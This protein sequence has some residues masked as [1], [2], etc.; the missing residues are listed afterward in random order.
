MDDPDKRDDADLL[1][2]LMLAERLLAPLATADISS[3]P[4]PSSSGADELMKFL[5]RWIG[6]AGRRTFHSSDTRLLAEHYEREIERLGKAYEE[7]TLRAVTKER[8]RIVELEHLVGQLRQGQRQE[9]EALRQRIARLQREAEDLAKAREDD[10]ARQERGHAA[11]LSRRRAETAAESETAL[12]AFHGEMEKA[13]ARIARLEEEAALRQRDHANELSQLRAEAAAKSEAAR[14]GFQ[15]EMT[16]AQACIARLEEKAAH[17]PAITR[18]AARLE[19]DLADAKIR[20]EKAEERARIA[21]NKAKI[22]KETMG[23]NAGRPGRRTDA[24]PEDKDRFREAKR[25]FALHFHPDQGGRGDAD[26]ERLF[27]E[28]WPMLERI[29]RGK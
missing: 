24:A 6:R 28:F 10:L 4:P 19:T 9:V 12:R 3:R 5:R 27:L 2:T 20:A 8:G 14:R 18:S 22:L 7:D 1:N 13:L 15:D 21:E 26:K 11:E 25:A 29:E 16:R 23:I 17:L